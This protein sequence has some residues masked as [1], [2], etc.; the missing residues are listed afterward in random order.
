MCHHFSVLYVLPDNKR[1][2]D[3][4]QPAQSDC[5]QDYC[6][7]APVEVLDINTGRKSDKVK[8]S[9]EYKCFLLEISTNENNLSM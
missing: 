9:N 5:S 8:N 6:K 3:S 2:K 1:F 7:A 4:Y